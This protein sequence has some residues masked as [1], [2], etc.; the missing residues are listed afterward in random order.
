MRFIALLLSFYIW[1]NSLR[2]LEDKKVK[3][4]AVSY[5]YK[6]HI[7]R[8][9]EVILAYSWVHMD[10]IL[11]KIVCGLSNIHYTSALMKERAH[12]QEVKNIHVKNKD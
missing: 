7:L 6:I 10:F 8:Y 4:L 3:K 9:M 1:E 12:W 2:K 5:D 11:N